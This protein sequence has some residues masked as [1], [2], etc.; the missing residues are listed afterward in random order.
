MVQLEGGSNDGRSGSSGNDGRSVV[1][2]PDPTHEEGS[3]ERKCLEHWNAAV[4]VD[5]GKSITSTNQ[6]SSQT[7]ER[8]YIY[9]RTF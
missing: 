4:G 3:G 8:K 9:G 6:R 7:N 5:E 1:W 2:I